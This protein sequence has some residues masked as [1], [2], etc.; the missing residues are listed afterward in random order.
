MQFP[1]LISDVKKTVDRDHT[2]DV[3]RVEIRRRAALLHRLGR[4]Q[5]EAAE[6]CRD[7]LSWEY[8]VH[9][10]CVIGAEVDDLVAEVYRRG[11]ASTESEPR[12]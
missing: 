12:P 8:E 1:W 6:R 5:S 2:L 11:P 7:N 9:G 10:N 3:L 4:T